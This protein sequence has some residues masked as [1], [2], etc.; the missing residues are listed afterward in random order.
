MAFAALSYLLVSYAFSGLVC[1]WV[2]LEH[3]PDPYPHPPNK[4]ACNALVVLWAWPIWMI[5]EI[6][7]DPALNTDVIPERDCSSENSPCQRC[8]GGADSCEP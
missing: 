2:F 8:P 5:W 6:Y 7:N 3:T 1:S 4:L